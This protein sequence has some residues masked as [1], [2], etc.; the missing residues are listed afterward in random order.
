MRLF[1]SLLARACARPSVV[2]RAERSA[3]AL[4]AALLSSLTVATVWVTRFLPQLDE[5][6]HLSAILIWRRL[7][8]HDPVFE[9]FYE[10]HV[11][12]VAYS[13]HYGLAVLLA[14]VTGVEAAHKLV[15]SLSM[16]AM[17]VAA[18]AWCVRT[19]RSLWLSLLTFPFVFNSAWARGYHPFNL[20]MAAFIVSVVASDA[21]LERPT[22]GRVSLATL[23]VTVCYLGHPFP[24]F[25]F[26]SLLPVLLLVHRADLRRVLLAGVTALPSLALVAWQA[27]SAHVETGA[28]KNI[29][30]PTF[31]MLDPSVWLTRLLDVPRFA[32]DPLTANLDTRI[33]TGV[34]A[35]CAVLAIGCA[36]QERDQQRTSWERLFEYRGLLLAIVLL[37]EYLVLPDKFQKPVYMWMARGRIGPAIAFFAVLTPALRGSSLL[38]VALLPVAL[39]L[40]L[41][42]IQVA[43]HYRAF[44]AE[45]SAMERLLA[46][47]PADQHVLSVSVGDRKHPDYVSPVFDHLAS[48]TQV[49]HGDF[50]P[51]SFARPTP[52]P[53]SFKKRLPAS[54]AHGYGPYRKAIDSGVYGCVLTHA[55]RRKLPKTRFRLDAKEGQFCLYKALAG[56][57]GS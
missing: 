15:V 36:W 50:N 3:F 39:A 37:C 7:V 33:G 57:S 23:A 56:H 24:L 53:F 48:W 28:A 43:S 26:F 10:L 44:G 19:H 4:L 11:A 55:L 34:F 35:L 32:V 41:V 14:G 13:A 30:G 45:M 40:T 5:A 17:P 18:Y 21:Y 9:Q 31:P 46:R 52:F 6:T 16:L 22:V 29:L 25:I 51:D 54:A 1:P 2:L 49:I 42:P 8:D 20:G 27:H 47:C 38:R 12:P